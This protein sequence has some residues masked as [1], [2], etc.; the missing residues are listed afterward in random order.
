MKLYHQIDLRSWCYHY[1]TF[2]AR[3]T[4]ILSLR[5]RCQYMSVDYRAPHSR[6]FV[7]K[8]YLTLNKPAPTSV[9][10]PHL[11][12]LSAL[13]TLNP[14]DFHQQS[15]TKPSAS[16][17]TAKA[18]WFIVNGPLWMKDCLRRAVVIEKKHKR[19]GF[20]YHSQM[21]ASSI[22]LVAKFLLL[23]NAYIGVYR[24]QTSK[25]HW[26]YMPTSKLPSYATYSDAHA[27]N[28]SG[29]GRQMPRWD[30]N[31]WS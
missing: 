3:T 18:G 11:D 26:S 28:V 16:W 14:Q 6:Y 10:V 19:N 22:C 27:R 12:Y 13:Y 8:R 2:T 30:R 31:M 25:H 15:E 17:P 4:H 5:S 23:W 7:H 29:S 24:S 20:T 9:D 1:D 21:N